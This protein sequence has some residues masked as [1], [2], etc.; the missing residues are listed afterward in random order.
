MR[1]TQFFFACL[2]FSYANVFSQSETCKSYPLGGYTGKC[3]ISI[4]LSPD[5]KYLYTSGAGA[6]KKWDIAAHKVVSEGRYFSVVDGMSADGNFLVLQNRQRTSSSPTRDND[7]YDLR[8][9]KVHDPASA[10]LKLLPIEYRKAYDKFRAANISISKVYFSRDSSVAALVGF[11]QLHRL[12]IST[13]KITLLT[14]FRS[15]PHYINDLNMFVTSNDAGHVFIDLISERV[16]PTKL[17]SGPGRLSLTPDKK[18]LVVSDAGSSFVD[19]NTWKEVFYCGDC[20][21]VRFN[22]AGTK[23]YGF[24]VV[25][26]RWDD[27]FLHHTTVFDYPGFKS[28]ERIDKVHEGLKS[29]DGVPFDPDRELIFSSTGGRDLRTSELKIPFSIDHI[30]TDNEAKSVRDEAEKNARVG[31]DAIAKLA[32]MRTPVIVHQLADYVK[33]NPSSYTD[34]GHVM[35]YEKHTRGGAAILWSFPSGEPVA[36]YRDEASTADGVSK[37]MVLVPGFIRWA[38]ISPN[39][40]IVAI[41]TDKEIL[42][43]EGAKLKGKVADRELLGL[44]DNA[45]LLAVKPKAGTYEYKDLTLVDPQSGAV[46]AKVKSKP[47]NIYFANFDNRYMPGKLVLSSKD[48]ISILDPANP[49]VMQAYPH[50]QAPTGVPAKYYN[51]I[52]VVNRVTGELTAVPGGTTTSFFKPILQS[53][54]VLSFYKNEGIFIHDI[55]TGKNIHDK[56]IYPGWMDVGHMIYLKS[57]NKLLVT[58]TVPIYT[59]PNANDT[60]PGASVFTVDVATGE[61]T[62]YLLTEPRS[63]YMAQKNAEAASAFRYASLPCEEKNRSYKPGTT[64]TSEKHP[65]SIVIGYDC[66]INAYVVARR[67]PLHGPNSGTHVSRLYPLTEAEARDQGYT[68]IGSKWQICPR[69]KGYPVTVETRT[70]SGWS[71]WEQKSLNIYVYTREWQT[72]TD[73]VEVRCERCHGDA[74]IKY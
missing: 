3:D 63:K 57:I 46:L 60:D 6:I 25:A 19:L 58:N 51:G 68:N 69:C 41:V 23:F 55:A 27:Y 74:W 44:L 64:I 48:E 59:W 21:R 24:T 54:Y 20:Y 62:P 38:G 1:L 35:M 29:V 17:R 70:S 31:N 37:S 9:Y 16:Y 8:Y 65:I 30:V 18:Y 33:V 7:M 47:I 52:N 49:S 26:N 67:E 22:S 13:G 2:S 50:T 14:K 71:D 12:E 42:F 53:P 34:D 5:S 28:I 10:L 45:A 73:Q 15:E 40:K 56:P 66:E 39:G 4:A 72:T 43:Y 11:D 36:G 32:K 61:I